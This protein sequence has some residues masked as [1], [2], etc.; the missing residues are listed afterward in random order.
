MSEGER[1]AFVE[2]DVIGNFAVGTNFLG[3]VSSRKRRKKISKRRKKI[4]HTS[5]KRRK[6]SKKRNTRTSTG[7]RGVKYTKNGQPYKILANGRARFIKGK[8]RK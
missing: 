2:N 6:S 7:N 3:G 8:R 4:K 1:S 5:R